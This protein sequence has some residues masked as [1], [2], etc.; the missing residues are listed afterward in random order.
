MTTSSS[1]QKTSVRTSGH[2]GDGSLRFM[3]ERRSLLSIDVQADLLIPAGNH[4]IALRRG[5]DDGL[6]GRGGAKLFRQIDLERQDIAVHGHLD[7][8]HRRPP[9]AR[10]ALTGR[11]P[12]DRRRDPRCTGERG[13]TAPHGGA[14]A[15]YTWTRKIVR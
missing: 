10:R 12:N 1:H 2:S 14:S 13:R 3:R 15:K 9:F 6:A 5:N 8:L 4:D 7:V 11:G